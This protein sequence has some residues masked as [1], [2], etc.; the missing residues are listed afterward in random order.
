[1][2]K[3]NTKENGESDKMLKKGKRVIHLDIRYQ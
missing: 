3:T 1:M 2:M